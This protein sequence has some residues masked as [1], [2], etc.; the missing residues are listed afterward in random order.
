MNNR[1]LLDTSAV[2]RL[3]GG[4]EEVGK[5]LEGSI[6][7]ICP[8]VLGELYYGAGK[9]DQPEL[10]FKN[11]NLFKDQV[12]MLAYDDQ[13]CEAYGKILKQLSSGKTLI[14]QNTLWIAAFSLR[15]EMD[16]VSADPDFEKIEGIQ[17]ISLK[18]FSADKSTAPAR[19]SMDDLVEDLLS[20]IE[21]TDG[22]NEAITETPKAYSKPKEEAKDDKQ[23]ADSPPPSRGYDYAKLNPDL[24]GALDF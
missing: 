19:T 3:L 15:N 13:T 7:Y 16:L 11:I 5:L 17:Q 1:S 20:E 4:D 22:K 8:V 24:A 12:N 14:S 21:T 23:S 9:S 18:D 6:L 2:V 10:E